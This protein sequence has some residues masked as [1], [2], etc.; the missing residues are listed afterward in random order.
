MI[1]FFD[2]NLGGTTFPCY[3]EDHPHPPVPGPWMTSEMTAFM[4]EVHDTAERAAATVRA[5][6][7]TPGPRPNG[8][9]LG[10]ERARG[11]PPR[12]DPAV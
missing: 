4:G 9:D 2:Q 10:R 1:Q 11:G 12:F 8:R 6:G 7:T 5:G 3:A